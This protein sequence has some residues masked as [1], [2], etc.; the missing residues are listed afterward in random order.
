M[1]NFLISAWAVMISTAIVGRVV[2][3]QRKV[4]SR[5][6]L[7]QFRIAQKLVETSTKTAS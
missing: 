1:L 7:D 2:P 4:L 3:E 5:K 6:E